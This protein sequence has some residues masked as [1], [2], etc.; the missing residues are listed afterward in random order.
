MDPAEVDRL[1]RE[2]DR[3]GRSLEVTQV[4]MGDMIAGAAGL[5][6]GEGAEGVPAAL[7]RGL[8]LSAPERPARA[9][10]RPLGEDLFL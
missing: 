2:R 3:D 6:T 4:A 5:A 7:V 9:L 10:L 1:H 8:A